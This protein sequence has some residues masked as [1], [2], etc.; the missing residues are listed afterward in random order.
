LFATVSGNTIAEKLSSP[1]VT[2][3]SN[4]L[5]R[6][7]LYAITRLST[8]IVIS[9][10][11]KKLLSNQIVALSDTISCDRSA[12]IEIRASSTLWLA[13]DLVFDAPRLRSEERS[14]DQVFA[15][16]AVLA[17]VV[18]MLLRGFKRLLATRLPR[19]A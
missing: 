1:N 6:K 9:L 11:A 19:L 17:G 13:E 3:S 16:T 10:R 7:T 18:L 2:I 15:G 8:E 5:L 4:T 12:L 14:E